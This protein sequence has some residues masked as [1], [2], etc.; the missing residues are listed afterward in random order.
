[1]KPTYEE[2]EEQLKGLRNE[3]E[4]LMA[5]EGNSDARFH[6]ILGNIGEVVTIIDSNGINRFKSANVEALFGWKPEELVGKSTW[7]N[8]HPE[9]MESSAAFFEQLLQSPNAS[10]SIELRY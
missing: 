9:D 2:L 4:N 8:V 5:K 1:M 6:K 10:A 3:L 7:E